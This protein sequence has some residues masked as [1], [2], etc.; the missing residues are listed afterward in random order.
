MFDF[1]VGFGFGFGG[2]AEFAVFHHGGE[3]G[4]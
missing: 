3:F 4:L 1:D 2:G